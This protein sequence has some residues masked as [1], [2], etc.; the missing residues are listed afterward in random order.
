MNDINQDNLIFKILPSFT[1]PYLILIRLDRPIGFLLLFYPISFALVSYGEI[2]LNTLKFLIIFF[3]GAFV[4]RSVGCIVNDIFDRNIDKKVDRTKLRPLASS[5]ITLTKA[6]ILLLILSATGLYVLI[7]LNPPAIILGLVIAPLIVLYPLA[8]RF[9]IIP[10]L[11]LAMIYNWGSIIGWVTIQSPYK[12]NN[13][14]IL[15]SALIIW[16][17]IYDTVYATQDEMD[18]RKMSLYS[19]V[20]F[21]DSKRFQII[22][23]LICLKYALLCFFAYSLNYHFIFYVL[24]ISVFIVNLLD[25]HMKWKNLSQNALGYFK[26]NNHYALLILFSI[27]IGSQLNV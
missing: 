11:V 21:F 10:Q 20:I 18:D 5:Q 3:L 4:M 6:I 24:I 14:L 12:F 19:S 16:T 26:R 2:G 25:I 9:F 7:N 13:I 8:K 27:M 23:F 15:Y 17:I 22:N 1:H